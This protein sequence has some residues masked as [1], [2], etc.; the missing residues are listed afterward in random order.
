MNTNSLIALAGML[1]PS[2]NLIYWTCTALSGLTMN[3]IKIIVV[4]IAG[5]EET[6]HIR[7]ISYFVIASIIYGVSSTMQIIF[8]RS[9]YY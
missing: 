1:H 4:A 3:L 2:L 6:L 8:T 9:S 5:F 7:V